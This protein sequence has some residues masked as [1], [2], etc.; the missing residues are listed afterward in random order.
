[1]ACVFFKDNWP[2]I[3]TLIV[4]VFSIWRYLDS[5]KRELDWKKTEFLFD[6]A[7]YI[8]N[9]EY[10]QKAIMV[11]G[12]NHTIKA[13]DLIDSNGRFKNNNKE[14]V[15]GF[16]KLFNLLERLSYA[17]HTSQ[18]LSKKELQHFGWYYEEIIDNP[19]LKKYCE[20]NGYNDVILFGKKLTKA[21][22][23]ENQRNP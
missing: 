23:I 17:E 6:Q 10:I 11:I 16:E 9:D 15:E 18:V 21:R 5:R 2:I 14:I 22:T 19:T 7:K 3:S 12:G 20:K 8:D 1:M 4:A 13:D